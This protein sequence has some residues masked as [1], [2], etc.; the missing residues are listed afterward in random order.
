MQKGTIVYKLF[1]K[2]KYTNS[3]EHQLEV[4]AGFSIRMKPSAAVVI[5]R[6]VTVWNQDGTEK[7]K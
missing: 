6:P 7:V 5:W 2:R 1:G 3:S 4:I